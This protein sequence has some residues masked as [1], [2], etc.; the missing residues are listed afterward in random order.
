MTELAIVEFDGGARPNPGAAAIGYVVRNGGTETR[1][2]EHIGESTNNRAEYKALIG[3]L[4]SAR[5]MECS[6]VEARGDSELVV[7]QVRGEYSVNE[8]ALRPL[9]D[10]ARELA[11]EFGSFGIQHIPRDRNGDA[12]E[13]VDAAFD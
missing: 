3:G 13:L 6:A 2:S 1:G 12:H 4:E 10:R 8:P 9:R 11:G 7:K 5:E